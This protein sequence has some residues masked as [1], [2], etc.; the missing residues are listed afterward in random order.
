MRENGE[1]FQIFLKSSFLK[2]DKLMHMITIIL[3]LKIT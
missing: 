2:N 1:I 3:I